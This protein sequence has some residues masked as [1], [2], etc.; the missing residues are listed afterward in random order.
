[1]RVMAGNEVPDHTTL[2]RFRQQHEKAL[3]ELFSQV[4]VMCAKAGMGRLGVIA[5][6][7]TKIAANASLRANRSYAAIG[8]EVERILA[9]AAEAD[10]AE[11]ALYGEACGDE[12]PAELAERTS[13]LAR[14][15][16]AR[17]RLEAE[18]DVQQ[19]AHERRLG[20]GGANR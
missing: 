7:G 17:A 10:A 1:M 14:L 3:E 12:L 5:I 20:H 9:E 8:E 4:L 13:R 11:D 19:T 18:V 15:R 2:S 6:D 16:A